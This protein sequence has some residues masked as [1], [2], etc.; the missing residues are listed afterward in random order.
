MGIKRKS[1]YKWSFKAI[2]AIIDGRTNNPDAMQ[3]QKSAMRR[4]REQIPELN[5]IEHLKPRSLV[6]DK[7]LWHYGRCIPIYE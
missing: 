2:K 3:T 7:T 4:F 5:M 1:L 6:T